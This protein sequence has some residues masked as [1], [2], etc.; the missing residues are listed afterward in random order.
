MLQAIYHNQVK[1]ELRQ[2]LKIKEDTFTS[3]VLENLLLLPDE[4]FLE[5]LSNAAEKPFEEKLL[6]NLLEYEF[7]PHWDAEGTSNENYVEPDVFLRF[8]KADM[9]IEAK[10]YDTSDHDCSQWQN[11]IQAYFNEYRQENEN[12]EENEKSLIFISLGGTK[13]T[14]EFENRNISHYHINWKR[15]HQ[16]VQKTI[17]DL[18]NLKYNQERKYFLREYTFIIRILKNVLLGFELHGFFPME[19]FKD[20]NFVKVEK[21]FIEEYEK[22]LQ[23][24]KDWI[25]KTTNK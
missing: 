15:L 16:E 7:W 4:L 24:I 23:V 17:D 22:S 25:F 1:S 6:G 2:Y 20:F 14:C 18:N 13:L 5:I 3:A 8:E 12:E 10:R 9:I 11:E 21:L 19:W